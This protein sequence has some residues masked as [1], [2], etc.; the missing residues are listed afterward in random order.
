MFEVGK[1]IS[2]P[3]VIEIIPITPSTVLWRWTSWKHKG[4]FL[5]EF[6]FLFISANNI[7]PKFISNAPY[8][9]TLWQWLFCHIYFYVNSSAD[10]N[11]SSSASSISILI[12]FNNKNNLLY[13]SNNC[14]FNNVKLLRLFFA[15]L[16]SFNISWMLCFPA[17]ICF[18]SSSIK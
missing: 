16:I 7:F 14:R 4:V 1:L 13:F 18:I 5:V 10:D 9:R 15:T 6:Y 17:S 8:P 3:S 2:F 11:S 12:F